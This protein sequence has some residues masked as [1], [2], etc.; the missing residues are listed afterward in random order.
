MGRLIAGV[1]DLETWCKANGR[2]DLLDEW[3]YGKNGDLKP[4]QVLNCSGKQVW[5]KCSKGHKWLTKISNRHNGSNCPYCNNRNV[6]RGYNDLSTTNPDLAKEWDYNKN[7]IL[8]TEVS[9]GSKIKIWW[10]CSKWK[11]SGSYRKYFR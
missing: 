2:E 8:P 5:W 1:N 3:D 4:N 6:L 7:T 9:K 10:I 11:S